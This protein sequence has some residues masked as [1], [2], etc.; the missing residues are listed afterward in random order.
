MIRNNRNLARRQNRYIRTS[1]LLVFAAAITALI[2]VL[3]WSESA[4]GFDQ[5]LDKLNRFVQSSSTSDAAAQVFREGRD[6]LA[7]EDWKNAERSFSAFISS[8]PSDRNI[9][10]ALFWLA[11]SFERQGRLREADQTLERLIKEHP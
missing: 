10:A 9:D 3:A 7:K 2:A 4:Y 8:Y 11:V 1:A 6:Y 5:E